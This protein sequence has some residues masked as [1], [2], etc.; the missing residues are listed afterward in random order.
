MSSVE[1]ESP[2][3]SYLLFHTFG[4]SMAIAFG[5]GC[6]IIVRVVERFRDSLLHDMRSLGGCEAH[7]FRWRQ[8]F[9]LDHND[10]DE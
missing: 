10:H 9:C 1:L 7:S 4:I 8:L 2:V 5:E 3:S 6:C